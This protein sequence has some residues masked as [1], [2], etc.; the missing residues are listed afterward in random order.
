[1]RKRAWRCLCAAIA[2]VALTLPLSACSD[3]GHTRLNFVFSK[4]EAIPFMHQV[5]ADYN[6]AHKD[7][8][9]VMDTSGVD[10]MSASFVRGNPPDVAL[11]NYNMETARFVER[12]TLSDLSDFGPTA[13]INPD[14]TP[15]MKQYGECEG[16]VSA[17]PYSIMASAVIYNKDTF[18]KYNLQVPKTWDEL[19]EVSQKLKDNGV[20]PFYGTFSAAEGWT[21][22]QGWFDYSVGGS[23][24]VLKF[25]DALKSE[26]EHVGAQSKVS[27]E[28]D[29]A[30][31][32]KKMRY[33]ADNFVNP[34]AFSRSY[35][36]G[37][38]NFAKG[39]AAMLMQGP[40]SFSEIAKTNPD[41]NL[42]T[43]PLP[44]TND[45][46]DL[47]VRVNVDLAG[48]IPQASKHKPQAR[49]FLNYLYS[50]EVIEKYN[51]SQLGIVP[52]EGAEQTKD[53]RIQGAMHYY[54]QAQFYQGPSV[55]ID[56]TIPVFNYTQEMLLSDQ[57]NK[58]LQTLDE[59]WARL[60]S[61]R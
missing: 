22:G 34:D 32:V 40:W 30:K 57:P 55:L 9:V 12:C 52:L 4:R 37:N 14:L 59:D 49:E 38:T 28:K 44:M 29:F 1:M 17:L 2:C 54:N 10:P 58:L 26:G 23:L 43:F 15:L 39:K 24:D 35:G 42:G 18:A 48:W 19:I 21:I 61:R 51:A 53:E 25:F 5:V 47:K 8:T 36:D 45:P 46:N 50:P 20:T 16:R 6:K 11:A 27:F 33:L 3:G 41:L 13:K 31:P 56:K 60:A 7:V